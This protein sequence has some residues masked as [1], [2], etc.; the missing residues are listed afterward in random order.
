[1]LIHSSHPQ[2][3]EEINNDPD[4]FKDFAKPSAAAA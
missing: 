3:K 1:M 4:F 2:V